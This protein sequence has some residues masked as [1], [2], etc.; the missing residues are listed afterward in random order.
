[1]SW[2]HVSTP[3]SLCKSNHSYISSLA[4][5][6]FLYPLLTFGFL[7]KNTITKRA[8]RHPYRTRSKSRTMGDQE[9]TQEQMKADMSALKEQMASMMEAML[10]MKQLMEKNAATAAAVSLA[11]EAD[12]TLLATTHHPPSNIVG[13]GRDTLGHDGSPHLGYNRA[14]Y[15]YGLPPNYSPPI[16]QED[17]GHIASP[18][19]ERE[20]PQQPDEVH[21]DPQDYARRDDDFYPP[22]PEGPAP[23]TLPQP[24]IAAPPIVLSMEGPPPATEERRKLDLLEERLR[25]VEGFGDYPFADMTDLCLVPDVVIPPKFKVP[26]FDKYKGTTCPKNHLKMY[27]R[28]MGAHSKDEKLL[29]HFFQDSLAGAA[30]VWYTNLE[31]SRIRTW[32]DLITAFLRQYQYNSDMAPDRTQLQNMFKKEGETFKEYAQRWRD[33]AAQVAPPM[34]EREMITMMVDTLPVF[35]YEKLVG[36]MPSSFADL[37]FAG[38]RI[39]VGLKRGKFDYVS[40]TSANAKRIGATG[41]KR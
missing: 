41:A 21:K 28:K 30:V 34:V 13:R 5:I 27:C 33:L 29:I 24:N 32:K 4:C 7:G 31:A 10:G 26:D 6:F 38:E 16:L 20:P 9:E 11:A 35:Y 19:H 18:V 25:A 12:P 2:S 39:E 8:T 1:M 40:S 37:V 22:I 23:G 36:Y 3:K 14:A 15:P 17:A